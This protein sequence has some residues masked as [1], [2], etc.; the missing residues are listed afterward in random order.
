MP[1]MNENAETQQEYFGKTPKELSKGFTGIEINGVKFSN[2]KE[3]LIYMNKQKDYITELN[4]QI[5]KMKCCGNCN[6]IIEGGIRTKKCKICMS[7]KDLSQW[8]LK[9]D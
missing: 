2:V 5:D 6:G 7:G 9:N 8:E 3:I 1:D 4:K